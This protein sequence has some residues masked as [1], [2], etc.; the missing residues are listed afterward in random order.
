MKNFLIALAFTGLFSCSQSPEIS[1]PFPVLLT[2]D[3]EWITYE[4]IL[5]SEGGHDALVE[6]KL[7]PGAPGYES[8]YKLNESVYLKDAAMGVNSHGNYTV[9]YGGPDH[10]L[11]QIKD[12][13]LI[14]SVSRGRK[15]VWGDRVTQDLLLKSNGDYEL[16][17]LDKNM[18]EVIP[19]YKLTRRSDLFTVEGYIT[20]A[21]D[22]VDFFERNT[23]QPWAV[24]KLGKYHEADSIYKLLAKEKFEGI[25]LKALGY[26]VHHTGACI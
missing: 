23:R 11:I 7:R 2:P 9:L 8:H 21:N 15:I 16:V 5:P 17:L 1:D 25:Y 18:Q 3:N 14:N 13:T 4:G 10:T 19:S 26:S 6:L 22:T 12:R 24:S 20:F